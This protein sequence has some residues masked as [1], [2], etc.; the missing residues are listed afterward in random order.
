MELETCGIASTIH[1]RCLCGLASL[2]GAEMR[3]GKD[4]KVASPTNKQEHPTR[5]RSMHQ[6]LR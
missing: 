6:I 1:V 4:D 5:T 2:A 3:L